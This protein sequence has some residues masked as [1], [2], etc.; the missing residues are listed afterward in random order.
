MPPRALVDLRELDTSRFEHGP[1]EIRRHNPHRFEMELLHGVV[2]YR[3]D[4]R[5]IVGVHVASEDA[6]WVRGHIPGRPLFPGVLMVEL[7]AQLCSFYW[8]LAFPEVDKFL[9]FGGIENTRFRGTVVPGDR[10]V[11]IGKSIEVKPRRAVF[12]CQGF[13]EATMVFETRIKGLPV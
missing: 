7:A 1:E 8:R 2:A 12:D 10:L 13:V 5:L 3:P 9:G 6:F 11:V 4:D